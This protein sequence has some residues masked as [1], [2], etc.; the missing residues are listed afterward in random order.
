MPSA[1]IEL[2]QMGLNPALFMKSA[3]NSY[4][5][6][7]PRC[8][9]TRRF[10]VFTD[11]PWPHW[12]GICDE[13]GLKG[14]ADQLNTALDIG[15]LDPLELKMREKVAKEL[16]AKQEGER[17]YALTQFRTRAD[18]AEIHIGM[19]QENK[20]WWTSQ[21]ISEK[22]QGF[23][24]LGYTPNR[25][26]SSNG[27]RYSSPC[28]TIPKYDLGWELTNMDYRLVNPPE[29][30]GKYRQEF[31]LASAAFLS[32]P[33][34]DTLHLNGV[35]YV[36][37]GSKKAMVTCIT[38]GGE[39]QVIGL[40]GCTSWA[41]MPERLAKGPERVYVLFDP[42]AEEWGLRFTKQVGAHA[43]AL[44]LPIKIDDAFLTGGLTWQAFQNMLFYQ[45]RTVT[46]SL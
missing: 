14:W 13:C 27:A 36:V 41:G 21:G 1:P 46:T 8:G 7:C 43:R 4:R 38:G 30:T 28:Y 16:I 34:Y 42:D 19:T 12:M 35:V 37:E 18:V 3:G 6:P 31:G 5:G 2:S 11:R 40:P 45:A 33:D 39:I 25:T 22:W 24:E 20:D 26:F 44:T 29:G 23:W 15:P 9:G 32:R 10:L 17:A